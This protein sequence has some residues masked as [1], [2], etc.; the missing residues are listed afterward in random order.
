VIRR[1]HL[2][3][4]VVRQQDLRQRSGLRP[5]QPSDK[6]AAL[7]RDRAGVADDEDRD[8]RPFGRPRTRRQRLELLE[9]DARVT[10]MH[11]QVVRVRDD[12]EDVALAF[13]ELA[14]EIV[15]RLQASARVAAQPLFDLRPQLEP[16]LRRTD[17]C[18]HRRHL[19]RRPWQSVEDDGL[20]CV[21][22]P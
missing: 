8:A 10:D 2:V 1:D 21:E 18:T 12:E 6:I 9:R 4:E 22:R 17:E 7:R 11:V 13:D 5:E 3:D 14:D 15:P 20:R 19:F 16:T